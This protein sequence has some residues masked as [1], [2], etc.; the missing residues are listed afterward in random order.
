MEKVARYKTLDKNGNAIVVEEFKK[1]IDT[2]SMRER[3]TSALSKLSSFKTSDG[4][5]VN[6]IDPNTFQ[7]VESGDILTLAEELISE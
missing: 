3:G 2:S 7:V 6:R 5:S 1:R 4:R